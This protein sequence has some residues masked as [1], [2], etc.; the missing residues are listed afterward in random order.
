MRGLR[1]AEVRALANHLGAD[2]PGIG[3]QLWIQFQGVLTVIVLSGVVSYVALYFVV[4]NNV[5]SMRALARLL[6]GLVIGGF[7]AAVFALLQGLGV[8]VLPFEFAK[9]TSFN[10][11]GTVGRILPS[12][13][14]FWRSQ[15]PNTITPAPVMPKSIKDWDNNDVV[16][17][18]IGL[19]FPLLDPKAFAA[20]GWN[21]FG[22]HLDRKATQANADRIVAEIAATGRPVLQRRE[23]PKD[24]M[25]VDGPVLEYYV[26][27]ES[28]PECNLP[29][30][31]FDY[32]VGLPQRP[33]SLPG[34]FARGVHCKT[35]YHTRRVRRD[36]VLAHNHRRVL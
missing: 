35:P 14:L 17:T 1:D 13:S 3:A 33:R 11:I 2:F 27:W 23:R 30:R 4:V 32:L 6:Y 15:Y 28:P 19:S 20:A 36:S 9:T 34:A 26:K 12:V 31:P 10:T 16:T 24:F 7:I 8:F 25:Y 18:G 29:S 5:R 22:V 21:V